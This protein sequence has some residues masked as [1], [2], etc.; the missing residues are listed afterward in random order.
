MRRRKKTPGHPLRAG[1]VRTDRDGK[2]YGFCQRCRQDVRVY[3]QKGSKGWPDA[4][5]CA[6]QKQV[7]QVKSD[8]HRVLPHM[9]DDDLEDLMLL[10]AEAYPTDR[11]A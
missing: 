4:D 5:V 6:R 7:W 1:T 2:R 11:A 10:L 3:H 9:D 8:L